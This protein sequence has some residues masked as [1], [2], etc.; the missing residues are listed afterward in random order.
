[1]NLL[2][3]F[4]QELAPESQA[5]DDVRDYATWRTEQGI[6]E[7]SPSEGSA[8]Q[9]FAPSESDDVALRTYLLQLRTRGANRERLQQVRE[10][11]K[12]FYSWARAAGV[13]AT[14]PFDEFNF[15]R[16]FLPRDQIRRRQETAGVDPQARELAR[17]HALN[18]VA[19]ELNRAAD[20][21]TA[22]DKTLETLLE[23]MNLQTAWAF[24]LTASGVQ[25]L[26]AGNW[27]PH[28]FALASAC[29]LP[30][31]LEQDD[32]RFLRQPPDCHCQ[33]FFREGHLNRAVN[34][35]ECTRLQEAAAGH[36]DIQ[37]LLYHASVP[38][39]S[40]GQLL[41]ILNV[42]T[43]EWQ[44]L[45]AADLQFL[46]NVG[47]QV[48]VALERAQ[49]Y[50][51]VQAQRDHLEHELSVAHQVQASLLPRE[52]PDLPGFRLA[53][54]WRSARE[55]AG[56][57]YDI[58]PLHEGHWGIVVGDVSDKGAP[59]ALYM[60]MT[61]ALIRASAPR[62]HTP[63]SALVHVNE[64]ILAQSS[65]DMFLT[66]LYAVLDP[67]TRTLTYANAGHNPPL[68]RRASG[69]IALLPRTGRFMGA[70][71]NLHLAE[72]SLTLAPG[73]A[74]VIYTDG[75]TDA[76]NPAGEDYG[77]ER[78]MAALRN[79][80]AAAPELLDHLRAGLAACTQGAPQPDD[81]TLFVLTA[82]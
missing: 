62:Y 59:A 23:V 44:F 12:R 49:L 29:G 22:L 56:D 34:I 67:A 63:A 9:A 75:V 8:P 74:L 78:L 2:E 26:T 42:A 17:L 27:P 28:D 79:E 53:A 51:L 39:V 61:R 47:V 70:L 1:M 18:Q 58:F 81:I 5:L 13:V 19:A 41:G 32:R 38:L 45:S 77:L 35:V 21:Q 69:E 33:S 36:G 4:A 52:L 14:N 68:V 64:T 7:T 37:G 80:H 40:N 72:A 66:V 30:P 65:Y 10:S 11:L 15:E 48:A 6:A 60:A 55:V 73:D 46:T 50:D 57:F 24:V 82:E 31:G 71:E 25:N 76:L 20:V 54:D 43:H 3:R 16:P